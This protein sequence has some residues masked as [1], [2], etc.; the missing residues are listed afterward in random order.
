MLAPPRDPNAQP[1]SI[2][3]LFSFRA[4]AHPLFCGLLA[5]VHPLRFYLAA[6]DFSSKIPLN[7]VKSIRISRL[8]CFSGNAEFAFSD[9]SKG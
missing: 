8:F 6:E 9:V 7:A 5:S 3:R 1:Q 4:S 2:H